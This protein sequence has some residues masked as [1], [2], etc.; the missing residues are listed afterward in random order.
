M[1]T[2]EDFCTCG[3]VRE[4]HHVWGK[5]HGPNCKCTGFILEPQEP[6]APPSAD[7]T[8]LV[9]RMHVIIAETKRCIDD[10]KLLRATDKLNYLNGLVAALRPSEG[11]PSTLDKLVE[12]FI[13]RCCDIRNGSPN[14]YYAH[15]DQFC[16]TALAA[17]RRPS[18]GPE[19]GRPS[20]VARLKS[21]LEG[22]IELVGGLKP[23][24]NSRAWE[25]GRR[26]ENC[27]AML[28]ALPAG[29][30][31]G[32]RERLPSMR[33]LLEAILVDS[34]AWQWHTAIRNTLV[35]AAPAASEG[36]K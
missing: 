14:A 4:S 1:S 19:T 15:V 31:T 20:V 22:I 9:E 13:G 36:Q 17:I 12:E 33:H 28:A 18:E 2:P 7:L 25:A 23:S 11:P 5:C 16:K 34:S 24:Y 3:H 30:E 27:L 8:R 21:E 35:L 29:P 10:D 32:D 26:A 6:S